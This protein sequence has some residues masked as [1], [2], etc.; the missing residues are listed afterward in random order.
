MLKDRREREEGLLMG[1]LLG[2]LS[3]GG[4]EIGFRL[5][6]QLTFGCQSGD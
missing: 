3:V 6:D 1:L 2:S 5:I 4:G